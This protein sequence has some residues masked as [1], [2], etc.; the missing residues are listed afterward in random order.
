MLRLS[1]E[2]NEGENRAECEEEGCV[3][4]EGPDGEGH[5]EQPSRIYIFEVVSVS[6]STSFEKLIDSWGRRKS[7]IIKQRRG[8]NCRARDCS[9]VGW[10]LMLFQRDIDSSSRLATQSR[11]VGKRVDDCMKVGRGGK[12]KSGS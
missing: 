10:P 4:V 6:R 11:H 5:L 1:G 12:D 2:G 3:R 8:G 9:G 7:E